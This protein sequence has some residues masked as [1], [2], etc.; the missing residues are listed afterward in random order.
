MGSGIAPRPYRTGDWRSH[1]RST[2][3]RQNPQ[4]RGIAQRIGGFTRKEE[5]AVQM[6]LPFAEGGVGLSKKQSFDTVRLVEKLIA[7]G[8]PRVGEDHH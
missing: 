2:G 5:F 6:N 3:I 8:I 1:K 7:L 4:T